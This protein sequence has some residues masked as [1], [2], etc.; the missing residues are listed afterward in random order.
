M[1]NQKWDK[2][3][4]SSD[5][6]DEDS[7]STL[8][9]SKKNNKVS[10]LDNLQRIKAKTDT[11]M[12]NK[13]YDLA[14]KGYIEIICQI[15]LN[16][17]LFENKEVLT[18]CEQLHIACRLGASCCM[19]K[20]DNFNEAIVH[21]DK[22][23]NLKSIDNV[24]I[25]RAL[26]FKS[27]AL[28][29]SSNNKIQSLEA[30]CETS[31]KLIHLI[32]NDL[33]QIE[34]EQ[35]EEYFTLNS[36][37]KQKL[38]QAKSSIS[39]A[40]SKA[41]H[42][43]GTNSFSKA[44]PV[45]EKVSKEVL[46]TVAGVESILSFEHILSSE[47]IYKVFITIGLNIIDYKSIVTEY[48]GPNINHDEYRIHFEENSPVF[49]SKLSVILHNLNICSDILMKEIDKRVSQNVL[50]ENDFV[51]FSFYIL[52]ATESLQDLYAQMNKFDSAIVTSSK[53]LNF[54]IS[55]T[56]KINN[57]EAGGSCIE[58]D[59][60]FIYFRK[61]PVKFRFLFLTIVI[62]DAQIMRKLLAFSITDTADDSLLLTYLDA[63]LR[64]FNMRLLISFELSDLNNPTESTTASLSN[65]LLF[66]SHE[67]IIT[68][69]MRI[70]ND[71]A[72]VYSQLVGLLPFEFQDTNR[73]S[74]VESLTLL[75]NQVDKANKLPCFTKYPSMLMEISCPEESVIE[76]VS[77][78]FSIAG[79]LYIS[80]QK[81][82]PQNNNNYRLIIEAIRSF[83]YAG[84]IYIYIS[85]L[86]DS[87]DTIDTKSEHLITAEKLFEKS[88][89]LSEEFISQYFQ[90]DLTHISELV[91]DDN[92]IKE[93]FLLFGDIS[94][95]LSFVHFKLYQLLSER[96]SS[97]E[98]AKSE[99][100]RGQMFYL[101]AVSNIITN[102]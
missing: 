88:K 50:K 83:Y 43:L 64:I 36:S 67:S 57:F 82:I 15:T 1:N 17:A 86:K 78:A 35:K 65:M 48:A 53:V 45:Y 89:Y 52:H 42:L 100:L 24:Q 55:K 70:L 60:F 31:S 61:F 63:A 22:A 6:D 76:R 95:H 37:I 30:A 102:F 72:G 32:S 47:L 92:D 101:K 29:K 80:N 66:T 71:S 84:V 85:N 16:Q 12:Y 94:Y 59:S 23:L 49:K 25:S 75:T 8:T 87:L 73:I 3:N 99:A 18:E 2:F 19:I 77:E 10:N 74:S 34:N 41:L 33:E 68:T 44:K 21:I 51:D 27:I 9:I 91:K 38:T 20:T 97:I 7:E 28:Y 14:I 40:L 11:I 5:E 93:V 39:E 69:S 4:Y 90:S 26:Y 46:G 58:K 54:F 56:L 13:D 62:V 79:E 81:S 98:Y 96:R